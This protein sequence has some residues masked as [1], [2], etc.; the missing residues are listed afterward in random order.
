[1]SHGTRYV[2][3]NEITGYFVRS[4][5]TDNRGAL[6]MYGEISAYCKLSFLSVLCIWTVLCMLTKLTSEICL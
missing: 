6:G 3:M 1:M 5:H 4:P 2:Y